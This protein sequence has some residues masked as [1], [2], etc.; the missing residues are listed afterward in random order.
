MSEGN[1][2]FRRG[3]RGY[4]G[5]LGVELVDDHFVC[6]VGEAALY[7]RLVVVGISLAQPLGAIVEGVPERFVDAIED[8]RSGHEDLHPP[9]SSL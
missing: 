7:A 4:L 9:V 3:G 2:G 1:H 6:D 5:N 8:V